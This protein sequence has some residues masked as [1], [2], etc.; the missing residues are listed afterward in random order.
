MTDSRLRPAIGFSGPDV[1]PFT[2]GVLDDNFE[3]AQHT[4]TVKVGL[5]FQF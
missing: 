1:V 2:D 4:H 3:L 5:G